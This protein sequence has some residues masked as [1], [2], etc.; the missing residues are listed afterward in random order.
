M[1]LFEQLGN[2]GLKV[3]F[4][5]GKLEVIVVNLEMQFFIFIFSV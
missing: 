4:Q 1:S 2:P 5:L 3:L